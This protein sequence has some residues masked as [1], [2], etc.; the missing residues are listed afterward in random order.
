M[1]GQPLSHVRD[2]FGQA[3]LLY[4]LAR[5]TNDAEERLAHVL[6]AM[7]FE[8]RAIDAERGKAPLAYVL[9]PPKVSGGE[10]T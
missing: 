10:T 8:A 9:D 4:E 3:D 7:E 2:P 1:C 5:T 6:N